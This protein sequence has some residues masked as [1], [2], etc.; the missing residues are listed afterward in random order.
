GPLLWKKG[1]VASIGAFGCGA[2]AVLMGGILVG[3]ALMFTEENFLEVA[4]FA[5]A[6]H[7]PVMIIEGFITTF[8]IGYL[9]KVQPDMIPGFTG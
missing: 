4:L 3:L 5:V 6:A 7:I 1:V 9:K 8:A 2:S